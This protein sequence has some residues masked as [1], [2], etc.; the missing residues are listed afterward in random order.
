MFGK[1]LKKNKV[2][3]YL[4]CKFDNYFKICHLWSHSFKTLLT[5]G[6]EVSQETIHVKSFWTSMDMQSLSTGALTTASSPGIPLWLEHGARGVVGLLDS[7]NWTRC[8][9]NNLTIKQRV[10][11]FP[12]SPT[13]YTG[14]W[15]Q[16]GSE[17]LMNELSMSSPYLLFIG[18]NTTYKVWMGLT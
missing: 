9:E 12:S 10:P 7:K 1:V 8:L 13:E 2:T 11:C 16:D 6:E 3:W 17:H 18:F 14:A 5:K 4:L 15:G